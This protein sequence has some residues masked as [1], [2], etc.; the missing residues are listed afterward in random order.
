MPE[1]ERISITIDGQRVETTKGKSVLEA[2]LDAGIYIPN[3]CYSPK[4]EPY[5]GCRLC[6]VKVEGM[7]GLPTACTT[8]AADGMAV[9]SDVEEVNRIRRMIL[10]LLISDHPTECLSC[11]KNQACELQKVAE[12]L[13]INQ[14]RI[15]R[16]TRPPKIDDSNP[17]FSRDSS[18]CILCGRCV[19]V[20]HE[21]RGVGAIDFVKRGFQA[22]V[23]PFEGL[24]ADSRCESCGECVDI[25]PVG[26]LMPKQEILP[27]TRQVVTVCPYCGCGCGL[28][29]GTRGNRI[30]RV[31]AEAKNAASQ[32][33]LCVKGRFGLDFVSSPNRLKT[34]LI[35]RD[36]KLQEATWDE[37][38]GFVAQRLGEIR[39]KDGSDAIAAFCSAKCT[40]EENY[41]F[42]KLMRAVVGTNHVDHCAH[43]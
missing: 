1:N 35:R 28:V 41:L 7:R 37:A 34:P 24:I 27:P 17:F 13:G 32:G 43:L 42:Q 25:C 19:R 16:V 8:K 29:L 26:A 9:A 22:E 23:A 4:L 36:G 21:V 18:K 39:D 6:I 5:G 14:Q 38:L 12:H 10:E 31:R 3:L 33:H 2:A 30:V 15:E 11:P 40:N 20:C